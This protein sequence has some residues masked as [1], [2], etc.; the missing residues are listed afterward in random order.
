MQKILIVLISLFVNSALAETTLPK[1]KAGGW[2]IESENPMVQK[3][4]TYLFCIDEATQDKLFDQNANQ[5]SSCTKPEITKSGESF[6][7]RTSCEVAGKKTDMINTTVF[8]GDNSFSSKMQMTSGS[9]TLTM[10]SNGKYVGDCAE[11][12]TP[13]DMKIAGMNMTFN[14][15]TQKMTGLTAKDIAEMAKQFQKK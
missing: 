2:E 5:G 10:K 12:M 14:P 13:G 1:L 6:I 3:P 9:R 11:G 15:S 7:M 4:M 8:D